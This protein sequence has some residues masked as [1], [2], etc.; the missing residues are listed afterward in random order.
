[1]SNN[2]LTIDCDWIRNPEQVVELIRLC[3]HYHKHPEVYFIKEHQHCAKYLA[4]G[5][6]LYNLDEHHDMGYNEGSIQQ[7][8]QGIMDRGNWVRTL[9]EH[10]VDHIPSAL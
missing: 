2:V 1:M 3:K 4:S 9:I 6:T 10:S 8:K 7:S 5:D